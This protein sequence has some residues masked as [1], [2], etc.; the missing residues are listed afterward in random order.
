MHGGSDTGGDGI[1]GSGGTAAQA[2]GAAAEALAEAFLARQGLRTVARRVRCRGGEIDLVCLDGDTLVFVEVRL[3]S[4][5]G[6]GGAAESITRDKRRRIV[7]AAQWWLAGAG[8]AHARRPMRF[9]AVLLDGAEA[10]DPAWL[11]AA[12]DADAS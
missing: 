4:S 7:F 12:F 2:R 5:R 6:F 1:V 8:R 3:R 10:R 11:R 9:D